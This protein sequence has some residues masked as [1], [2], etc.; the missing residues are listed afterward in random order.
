[1]RAV[2]LL[3][4]L[5]AIGNVVNAQN[6]RMV[7][8][9]PREFLNVV[10]QG[11]AVSIGPLELT[12]IG[13]L[14]TAIKS[15]DLRWQPDWDGKSTVAVMP[16]APAGRAARISVSIPMA[17][18]STA[19]NFTV[20]MQPRV[21]LGSLDN[22]VALGDWVIVTLASPL[23]PPAPRLLAAT[24][25]LGYGAVPSG[26]DASLHAQKTDVAIVDIDRPPMIS[27]STNPSLDFSKDGLTEPSGDAEDTSTHPRKFVIH[28]AGSNGNQFAYAELEPGTDLHFRPLDPANGVTSDY[29]DL[30][31][32]I[33]GLHTDAIGR[34]VRI[35]TV[36]GERI[37]SIDAAA[38]DGVHVLF[39]GP[40]GGQQ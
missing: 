34:P 13:P 22:S 12:L 9:Y 35:F 18:F 14:P 24:V 39:T 36:I 11:D 3:G 40:L 26:R 27:A 2:T 6:V 29:D 5:L 20:A 7:T 8:A 21:F 33:T 31:K 16:T 10:P 30:T 23:A 38:T 25:L 19:N 28:E 32:G 37:I 15:T 17:R 4:A 1:M